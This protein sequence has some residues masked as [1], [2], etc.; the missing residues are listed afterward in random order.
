MNKVFSE[1]STSTA[2]FVQLSKNQCN[3]LLRIEGLKAIKFQSKSGEYGEHIHFELHNVGT[4]K[5]LEARG[6]VFWHTNGLGESHGFGGLTKAGELMVGLLK[7][8][9]LTIE[10]TNSV[11]ILKKIA[12][13]PY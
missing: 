12:N 4:Y 2:F 9:G 8:A 3:A 11:S 10:S 6:L 7:E 5:C 13:Q 1:Y